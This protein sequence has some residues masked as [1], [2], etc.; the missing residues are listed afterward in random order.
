MK[1]HTSL[2]LQRLQLGKSKYGH[3]VRVN[4]DTTTWGTSKDSWLEMANEEFLDGIIYITCDYLRKGR[5]KIQG[6]SKL[7]VEFNDASQ[8]YDNELIMYVIDNHQRME[9]EGHKKALITLL[10]LVSMCL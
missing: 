4:S 8:E 1:T 9:S 2:L 3:G 10:D 6:A 5:D 7:E